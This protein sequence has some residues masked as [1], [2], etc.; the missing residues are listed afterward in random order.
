MKKYLTLFSSF[1]IMLS[2]G[3]VY[4]WSIFSAEL[5]QNFKWSSTQSQLVFGTLIAVFPLTMVLV[6]K[7]SRFNAKLNGIFSAIFFST[8]YI[9]SGLSQGNFYVILFGIGILAGIG[10]GFG[11]LTAITLPVKWFPDRKGLVT[12][13]IAA[14]FGLAA[15]VFSSL[16]ELLYNND[17][18]ILNIFIFIGVSYGS[19]IFLL[20]FLIFN[21]II[22][23]HSDNKNILHFA[24]NKNFYKLFI[25]IFS[26]TFAGLI[27][28]GSL[29][30]IGSEYGIEN[31]FLILVV[32]IFAFANFIG[33]MVWGY[34]SDLL[35]VNLTIFLALTFQAT[36][37][38]LLG[39]KNLS[40]ESF[41]IFSAFIGLGF[42]ANFVLF[43]KET[44]QI[45]GMNNLAQIYP[46]VFLGYAIA[47]ILGPLTGGVLYDINESYY[48]GIIIASSISFLGGIIFLYNFF[49][50]FCKKNH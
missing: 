24:W 32:S 10:T 46:Y 38:F 47:G 42:G 9:I 37:I 50:E 21:P 45:F 15:V 4:A 26:G 7:R 31:H 19:V 48:W 34:L 13:I 2:L 1:L 30:S 39:N 43:A 49:I 12:G 18:S 40:S 44:S 28:I 27:V 17:Y 25:G 33:R 35:N 23:N 5:M 11:Y 36:F 8:G 16:I 41:I 14:G 3:G 20:S 22:N 6:G 29:K